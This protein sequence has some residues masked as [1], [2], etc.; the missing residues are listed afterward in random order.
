[1][2]S[3]NFQDADEV[4]GLLTFA[5]HSVRN[6]AASYWIAADAKNRQ[7]LARMARDRMRDK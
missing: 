3:G 7:D 6:I 5:A 4:F 2:P 1:V